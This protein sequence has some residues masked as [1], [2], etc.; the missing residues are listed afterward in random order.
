MPGTQGDGLQAVDGAGVDDAAAKGRVVYPGSD[1]PV[2]G[3]VEGNGV[4]ADEGDGGGVELAAVCDVVAD[5]GDAALG[6]DQ[7]LCVNAAG[8][9]LG[10]NV[11]PGHEVLV[12]DG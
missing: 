12:A 7:P 5:E 9:G 4:A 11:F 10:E 8:A 1:E 3:E 6:I 2:A